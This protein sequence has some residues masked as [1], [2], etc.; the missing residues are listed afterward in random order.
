M[1]IKLSSTCPQVESNDVAV[2]PHEN[3]SGKVVLKSTMSIKPQVSEAIG[4]QSIHVSEREKKNPMSIKLLF[5]STELKISY[6]ASIQT[7]E[8]VSRRLVFN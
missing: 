6:L 2:K 5:L 4:T 7:H 3:I 8:N 1:S